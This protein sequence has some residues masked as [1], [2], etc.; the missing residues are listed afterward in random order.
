MEFGCCCAVLISKFTNSIY[1][2]AVLLLDALHLEHATVG[3]SRPY[4]HTN[5]SHFDWQKS[6]GVSHLSETS[7]SP[8]AYRTTSTGCSLCQCCFHFRKENNPYSN[9]TTSSYSTA[10]DRCSVV[11]TPVRFLVN[12]LPTRHEFSRDRV[13][14]PGPIERISSELEYQAAMISVIACHVKVIEGQS[15]TY[16]KQVFCLHDNTKRVKRRKVF[17][18]LIQDCYVLKLGYTL[19]HHTLL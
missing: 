7:R 8:V 18:L 15:V 10:C 12:L 5:L 14:P 6:T 3:C 13:L 16:L 11:P 17:L 1:A 4:K 2:K 19:P 9:S